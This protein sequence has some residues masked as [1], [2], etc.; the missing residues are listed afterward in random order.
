MNDRIYDRVEDA[1][2][3][4]ESLGFDKER[5][6]E[7]SARVL[8]ALLHLKPADDW[9]GAYSPMLG[10]RAIMDWIRDHYE[11]DYAANRSAG[12]RFTSSLMP[13]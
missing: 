10:T 7:R 13:C 6:N 2:F 12:L 4:L 1:R 8:L 5:T 11:V 9:S 3:I